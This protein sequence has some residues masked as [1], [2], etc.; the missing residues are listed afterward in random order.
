[1]LRTYGTLKTLYIFHKDFAPM[2]QIESSA[3]ILFNAHDYPFKIS[4]PCKR[5]FMLRIYGTLKTLYI[6]YKD[7]APMGQVVQSFVQKNYTVTQIISCAYVTGDITFC[8][9][10]LLLLQKLY[11]VP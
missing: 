2:G 11:H 6:F 8:S 1:V 4:I 10:K 5:I 9:N 7:F 3:Q